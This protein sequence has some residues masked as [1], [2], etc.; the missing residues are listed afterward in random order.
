MSRL[1]RVDV[2]GVAQHVI[3]R[4]NDRQLCFACDE[5]FAVY[6]NWLKEYAEEYEVEV[7]AWVFMTNH[8]HL[9]M[10]S[11]CKGGIS[12]LMQSLGRKYVQYFNYKYKRTGTLWEG[13]FR[14]CLVESDLY[15]LACYRYIELNPVRANMVESPKDYR[16]SSY[17]C[18]ALGVSSLMCTSH[19]SYL[20]LGE[21]DAERLI[22]Y[23]DSFRGVLKDKLVDDIRMT[24]QQGLVLGSDQF[25]KQLQ[26]LLGRRLECRRRGRP[27]IENDS[28]PF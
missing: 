20:V 19:L 16:W 5:D 27:R 14:S 28:D 8:V 17:S 23:R 15:V 21:S 10:T 9:L 12:K 26:E 25:R 24:T 18:N 1:P 6:A 11:Y 2:P 4:G 3:Q 7:Y 22:K 13:R